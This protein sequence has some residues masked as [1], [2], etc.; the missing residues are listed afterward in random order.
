MSIVLHTEDERNKKVLEKSRWI[1]TTEPADTNNRQRSADHKH[2][3][4]REAGS[5]A[6]KKQVARSKRFGRS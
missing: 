2:S 6:L 3:L 1:S 4:A 5:L